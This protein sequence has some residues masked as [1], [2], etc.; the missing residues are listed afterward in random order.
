MLRLVLSTARYNP[1]MFGIRAKQRLSG[2]VGIP[3]DWVSSPLNEYKNTL[4]VEETFLLCVSCALDNRNTGTVYLIVEG[5]KVL[6]MCSKGA[7][8]WR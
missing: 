2:G 4:W 8:L 7:V 5:E 6:V 1:L 3:R